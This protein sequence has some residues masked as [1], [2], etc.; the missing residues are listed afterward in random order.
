VLKSLDVSIGLVFVLLALSMAVTVITQTVT[1]IFN[2]RG[3]HLRRGLMDLLKLVDPALTDKIGGQ[4]ATAILTHPLVSG[5]TLKFTTRLGNVVHREEFTKLLMA[6]AHGNAGVELEQQASEVLKSALARNGIANPDQTLQSIRSLA[7]QLERS[8][9]ELSNMARQNIAILNGAQSDLVA[10]INTW[11]DQTIDR[12]SQRFT[13]STRVI[14]FAGAV[15]VAVGLQVDAVSVVNRLAADDKMREAFVE[16]AKALQVDQDARARE[17]AAAPNTSAAQPSPIDPTEID[18]KYRVFLAEN[19]IIKLP[20]E[21]WV[22]S[23]KSANLPG[24]L[25]TVLLL[26]LGAPFWYSVLGKLLQ[27]RSVLAFKDDTQR[28][29]RQ[30]DSRSASGSA[31]ASTSTAGGPAAATSIIA[32]ERG[33]LAAVG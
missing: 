20:G 7:L 30:Q 10:K 25:V 13:A 8:N 24:V 12:T 28:Q 21:G 32:G 31:S 14:T 18:R 26:S 27:L 29:E 16:Q 23:F 3:S 5:S 2:S 19:G 15:V 11:F 33:D 22:T 1:T 17:V 4:V 6:L 9:P